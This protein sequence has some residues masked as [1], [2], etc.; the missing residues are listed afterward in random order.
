M[1]FVFPVTTCKMEVEFIILC[2]F[3]YLSA[4]NNFPRHL[5]KWLLYCCI[6]GGHLGFFPE[7]TCNINVP[8]GYYCIV[9]DLLVL[10]TYI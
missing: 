6:I 7:T 9:L 2:I 8:G 5:E 1:F 3:F 10:K 4:K